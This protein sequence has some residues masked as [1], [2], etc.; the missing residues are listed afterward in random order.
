MAL[1]WLAT[2]LL[3]DIL[4]RESPHQLRAA[5]IIPV[6]YVF[7]ALGLIAAVDWF[8][9]VKP[10][11]RAIWPYGLLTVLILW[12]AGTS[13]KTFFVDWAE[14]QE[15]ADAFQGAQQIAGSLLGDQEKPSI[16]VVATRVYRGLP[17]GSLLFNKE[18]DRLGIK[19]FEGHYCLAIPSEGHLRYVVA[20]GHTRT[21]GGSP[22]R[23]RNPRGLDDDRQER[24]APG[25]PI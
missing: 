3:P 7:P 22:E 13:A 10:G 24:R 16:T 6:V 21:L 18:I 8:R 15:T 2:M 4:S 9:K 17:A 1:L 5:G 23:D 20:K 12:S 25:T 19:L 11:R 14:A